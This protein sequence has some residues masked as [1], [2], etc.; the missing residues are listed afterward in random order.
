MSALD[1]NFAIDL[2]NIL[3]PQVITEDGTGL[4]IPQVSGIDGIARA[5]IRVGDLSDG[6]TFTATLQ[7]SHD[8]AS[9]WADAATFAPISTANSGSSLA[10]DT[11]SLHKYVRVTYTA[12][13]GTPNL[14][15]SGFLLGFRV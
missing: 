4:D 2:Q 12:T 1:A 9:D 7:H 5:V 11:R 10:V 15:A 6:T 13:G 14:V 8:G 3:R